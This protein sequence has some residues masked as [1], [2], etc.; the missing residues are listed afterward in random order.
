CIPGS[1]APTLSKNRNAFS[2]LW[3]NK[4][5]KNERMT[6]V[7]LYA[8]DKSTTL[9]SNKSLVAIA[10]SPNGAAITALGLPRRWALRTTRRVRQRCTRSF[11]M[12]TATKWKGNW[13]PG[14]RVSLA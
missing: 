7:G 10:P 12:E 6:K 3:K 8:I 14:L 13:A 1:Y 4:G 5:L 11:D 9:E 2:R